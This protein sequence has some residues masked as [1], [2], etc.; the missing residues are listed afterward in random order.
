MHWE[1]PRASLALR[2]CMAGGRLPWSARR[3]GG[4]RV[5]TGVNRG[6]ERRARRRHRVHGGMRASALARRR[7][8]HSLPVRRALWRLGAARGGGAVAWTFEGEH[9]DAVRQALLV[10]SLALCTGVC[11]GRVGRVCTKQHPFRLVFVQRASWKAVGRGDMPYLAGEQGSHPSALRAAR[12][13]YLCTV[14][15]ILPTG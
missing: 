11:G 15:L 9:L 7:L 12:R 6:A 1:G 8:E 5:R 3:S 13:R 14:E 10:D 2:R 4:G